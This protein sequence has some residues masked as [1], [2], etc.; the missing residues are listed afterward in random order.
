[1]HEHLH[2]QV[3]LPANAFH[4]LKGYFARDNRTLGAQ[5]LD[6]QRALQVV[7]AHLGG[8]M[9]LH[10]AEIARHIGEHGQVLRDHAIHTQAVQEMQ[11]PVHVFQLVLEDDGVHRHVHFHTPDVGIR[12]R[13]GKLL[14]AE[15]G[16]IGTCPE[17]LHAQVHGIASVRNRSPQGF[18]ASRRGQ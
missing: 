14:L 2:G 5:L 3:R 1:M 11:L 7:N 8:A 6:Q 17:L 9:S 16:G 15:V 13:L 10:V 4:L 18:H 12:H